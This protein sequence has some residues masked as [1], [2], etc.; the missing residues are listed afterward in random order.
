VEPAIVALGRHGDVLNALGI[1]WE[2]F[3]RRMPRRP[4]AFCVGR[5]WATTLEGASYVKPIIWDGNYGQRDEAIRKLRESGWQPIVA[6]VYGGVTYHTHGTDSYQREAWREAGMRD[7]FG[8]EPLILDRRDDERE[9]ELLNKVRPD[10]E[11]PFILVCAE[12]ISS[13]IPKLA[14]LTPL[15]RERF[16]DH[17]IIDIAPIRAHRIYDLLGLIDQADLLVS[18]DTVHLHLARASKCPVVAIINDGW[19]GSVPP[20]T[21]VKAFRYAEVNPDAVAEAV[22]S[23]LTPPERKVFHAVNIHGQTPRHKKARASWKKCKGLIP[24]YVQ[25]VTRSALDIGDEKALPFLRDIL[26]PAMEKAGDEDVILWTNDDVELDPSIVSWAINQ[27][28]R[29]G[30]ATMRRDESGHCGRELFAFT[31]RWLRE[32]PIPDFLQG[33]HQFDLAVAAMIRHQRG[34]VS[35]LENM[36]VDFFPC[37]ASERL[38]HHEPHENEWSSRMDHPSGKHNTALF[39]TWLA[40]KDMKFW[41]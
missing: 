13:P 12:G 28:G 17:E 20:P 33:T 37:D 38:A 30:A 41:P 39:S 27:V 31:K 23:F 15:L 25:M 32:N 16:P 8:T 35:T 9:A 22:R 2:V 24:A 1:A 36:K 26:A 11:K 19:R 10:S 5:E 6:Q 40:S 7:R 14:P 18:V 29:Y 21:T 3:V 34:I 4:V